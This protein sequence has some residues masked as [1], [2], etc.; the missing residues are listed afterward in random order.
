MINKKTGEYY[1]TQC[2]NKNIEIMLGFDNKFMI[3]PKCK[4]PYNKPS[5]PII[6]GYV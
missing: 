6:K 1:C 4:F 3:C 5:H 2:L